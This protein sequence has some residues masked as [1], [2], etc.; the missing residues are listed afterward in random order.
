MRTQITAILIGSL[1]CT[2]YYASAQGVKI[3]PSGGQ[4]AASA[5]LDVDFPD[6]GF[7][8]PRLTTAQRNAIVAPAN[9]LQVYNTT[10]QCLEIYIS[11]NWIQVACACGN[12]V[13]AGFNYA[14]L[15]ISTSSNVVFTPSGS[16]V[17]HSWSFSGGNPATSTLQSPTVNWS[18]PGTY[19]VI[20]S[21]TDNNNCT[22][23]DTV[24]ITVSGCSGS[25]TFT[26]TGA[27]QTFTVPNCANTVHIEVWGAQGGTSFNN[28]VPTT[29]GLG[30]YSEGDLAVTP[31]QTLLVYVGRQGAPNNNPS[32]GWNGGA[33]GGNSINGYG[34][35]GGDGSDVRVG[36]STF[37]H[38]IIVAGGGGGAWSNTS[39][40]VGSG[41][42]GGGTV[43]GDWP[44]S[45]AV[46]GSQNQGGQYTCGVGNWPTFNGAFGY[47]GTYDSTPWPSGC[48]NGAGGGGGWYGGSAP[49]GCYAGPGAGGSGY[50]GGVTN[51]SMQT[52]VRTGNGEIII[53]W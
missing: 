21:L 46:G 4:P 33:C 35:G 43:G 30:G 48:G 10:S 34:G 22:N 36:G 15:N 19:T 2:G 6:K 26:Y 51:G 50:I 9:G 18:T 53:S 38:R 8:L 13:N 14:P 5:G 47:G 7:L 28:G 12:L 25:Q 1:L 29:G 49:S 3:S 52:G 39:F 27:Q 20:H 16:G 32:A 44:A 41:G 17:T 31:G 24:Q 40:P 11:P 37:N 42:A 45:G 23:S